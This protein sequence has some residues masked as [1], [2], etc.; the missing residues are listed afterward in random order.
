MLRA[1]HH[2]EIPGLFPTD[3]LK[4]ESQVQA[5]KSLLLQ[6]LCLFSRV[7]ATRH[8]NPCASTDCNNVKWGYCCIVVT[9]ASHYIMQKCFGIPLMSLIPLLHLL[10]P[11][12]PG[13]YQCLWCGVKNTFRNSVY[14][15]VLRAVTPRPTTKLQEHS[16]QCQIKGRASRITVWGANL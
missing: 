4:I 3:L 14:S 9:V 12:L 7:L 6:L 16:I 5:F 15:S 1:A 11:W 10:F 2:L 13:C 8:V